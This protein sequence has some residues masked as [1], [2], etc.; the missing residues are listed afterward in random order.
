MKISDAL[1]KRF[2]STLMKSILEIL[3]DQKYIESVQDVESPRFLNR[4]VVPHMSALSQL[5]NRLDSKD[6]TAVQE[7]TAGLK[8]YWRAARNPKNFILGYVLGF[9][10]G[11]AMRV[12]SVW[13]ELLKLGY[14]GIGQEG[15]VRAIELGAGPGS[16]AIG[17]AL[18]ESFSD[19]EKRSFEWTLYE[20]DRGIGELGQRFVERVHADLG[21][22]A[23]VQA[24]HRKL[25]INDFLQPKNSKPAELFLTSYF[26]NE[27]AESSDEIAE[28]FL[29]R[30]DKELATEA[31]I[32]L[33]EPALKV[34]SRKLLSFRKA[35]LER[36]QHRKGSRYQILLPC[37]GH[38]SCE[39]LENPKDWCHEEV[40]W[41]RPELTRTL[42]RLAGLDR[43]SLPYSYLVI[44]KTNRSIEEILPNAFPSR[45]RVHRLVSPVHFEGKDSEFFVCGE[46]GKRRVRFRTDAKLGRGSLLLGAQIRGEKE[47]GRVDAVKNLVE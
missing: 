2:D 44:A 46:D 26:M 18:G 3:A 12:A 39:A 30:W 32:I 21:L 22:D 24:V 31:L 29:K 27:L 33:V 15:P 45:T 4:S 36:I 34:E 25:S 42:D 41:W 47:A 9:M 20:Q 14:T 28:A 11:N 16:G 8:N 7:P 35:I 1:S 13:S 38:Q 37:L 23:Q 5:F 19:Q 10:P 43:K 17:I 6:K 40:T